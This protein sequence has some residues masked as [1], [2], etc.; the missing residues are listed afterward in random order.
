MNLRSEDKDSSHR[1]DSSQGS[2]ELSVGWAS[3]AVIANKGERLL[4]G[5]NVEVKCH[6]ICMPS[7]LANGSNDRDPLPLNEELHL[8]T[9][10]CR[11]VFG[12]KPGGGWAS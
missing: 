8:R 7:S 5:V 2:E 1:H 4:Q 6:P 10:K 3:G 12:G 9:R 11:C